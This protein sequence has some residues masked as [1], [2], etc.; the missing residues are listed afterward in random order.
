[1]KLYKSKEHP[2]HWIAQDEGPGTLV[3]WPAAPR[4][5][6]K[7]KFLARTLREVDHLDLE[8]VDP[9]LA[10]GTWWPGTPRS[11]RGPRPRAGVAAQARSIRATDAEVAAW[12]EAAAPGSWR[13]WA[14][15][16]LN[17]AAGRSG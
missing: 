1:M 11:A 9:A 17:E 3:I 2:G 6:S 13:T 8:E 7:R 15:R 14:T 4:G 16:T 5:W 12:S 10:R